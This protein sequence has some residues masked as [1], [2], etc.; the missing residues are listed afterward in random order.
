MKLLK[1]SLKPNIFCFH[2]FLKKFSCIYKNGKSELQN[3][4]RLLKKSFKY[5]ICLN[6]IIVLNAILFNLKSCSKNVC[7]Y[8]RTENQTTRMQILREKYFKNMVNNH[9]LKVRNSLLSR[10]RVSQC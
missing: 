2:K 9:F 6:T 1:K 8:I 3:C 4:L 7:E 5:N 10:K